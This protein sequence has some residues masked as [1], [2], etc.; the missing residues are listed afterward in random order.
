LKKI[1]PRNFRAKRYKNKSAKMREL[2][3][4]NEERDE[5]DRERIEMEND[6]HEKAIEVSLKRKRGARSNRMCTRTRWR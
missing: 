1:N 2:V 3:E 5:K 6:A 4:A